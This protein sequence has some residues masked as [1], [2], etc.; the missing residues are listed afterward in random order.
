MA[1]K[2][3]A[4]KRRSPAEIEKLWKQLEVMLAKQRKE[5]EGKDEVYAAITREEFEAKMKRVNSPFIVAHG[6]PATISPGG[7][8]LYW[9]QVICFDIIPAQNLA[10][11]VFFGNRN[12]IASNDEFLSSF[13]PRFPTYAKG[14]P[15]GFTLG[16]AGNSTFW[17]QLTIPTGIERTGYFGNTVMQRIGH[18]DVGTYLDRACFF[19]DVV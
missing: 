6:W 2:K 7:T 9:V 19:F 14:A 4:K 15:N 8:M 1:A 13:D 18:V 17:F 11:A 12:A 16:P 3:T 10:L 5:R